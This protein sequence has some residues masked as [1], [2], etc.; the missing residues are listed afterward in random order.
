[1][2]QQLGGPPKCAIVNERFAKHYFGSAKNA[3]GRHFGFGGNPG[4]RTDI[5]IVGVV[6]D[7]MYSTLRE[8]IPRQVFGL[9]LQAPVG[10]MNVYV[11]TTLPSD[12]MFAAIRKTV[13][14]IDRELPIF[15]LR[16]MAEQID[17]SLVTERMIA[18]L[19]AVFGMVATLLATVGLYGVMAYTVARK[20]REIGIRM[21]LGAFGKDVIWMVMREVMLLIAVGV[22]IGMISAL[23][24]TQFIEGQLYGL[25]P[26]DPATLAL[27]AAVLIVVAALAGYVPALRAS[28]VDPIRALRYE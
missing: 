20:T 8:Q 9:H 4:T 25:T 1:M 18:M 26:N 22:T 5:E 23:L 27:A 16:T 24:L 11:R 2:E 17:R 19:S 14:G 12:Q 21:A 28:R 13:S 6:R 7:S 15:D 3:V 10:S